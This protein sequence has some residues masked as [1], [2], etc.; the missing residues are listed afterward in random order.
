MAGLGWDG[1]TVA[2]G[3]GPWFCL[4]AGFPPPFLHVASAETGLQCP[5]GFFAHVDTML[6]LPRSLTLHC[7]S[8]PLY[9]AA[10]PQGTASLRPRCQVAV[11]YH[12]TLPVHTYKSLDQDPF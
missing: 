4:P 2:I 11:L 8:T 7:C 12:V 5:R 6:G 3:Q 1:W 9:P 10:L